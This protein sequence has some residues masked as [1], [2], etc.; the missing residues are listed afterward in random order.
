MIVVKNNR[1]L[2]VSKSKKCKMIKGGI[3]TLAAVLL[4]GATKYLSTDGTINQDVTTLAEQLMKDVHP[5]DTTIFGSVEV[6]VVYLDDEGKRF[7][8]RSDYQILECNGMGYTHI[9]Y[10]FKNEKGME[11]FYTK[12]EIDTIKAEEIEIYKR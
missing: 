8:A 2:N 11:L 3:A 6:G 9:G 12:E 1:S 10:V 5:I 4:V 7:L